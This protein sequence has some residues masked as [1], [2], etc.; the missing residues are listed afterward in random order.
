MQLSETGD[1]CK[2][3]GEITR[4]QTLEKSR[5]ALRKQPTTEG[6]LHQMRGEKEVRWANTDGFVDLV[7]SLWRVP[8]WWF[9]LSQF[10]MKSGHQLK[11]TAM[12]M[13]SLK[14]VYETDISDNTKE[15]LWEKQ[16]LMVGQCWQ[17]I[18]LINWQHYSSSVFNFLACKI[19]PN[20]SL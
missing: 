4:N 3:E 17:I 16:S 18:L 6:R 1:H 11:M 9:L 5:C 13:G 12:G 15:S 8:I 19:N 7:I 14:V 2:E 20:W 10:K